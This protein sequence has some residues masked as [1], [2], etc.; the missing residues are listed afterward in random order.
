MN[1]DRMSSMPG[2]EFDARLARYLEWESR[3]LHPIP[4]REELA[5]GSTTIG[6]PARRASG[7]VIRSLVGALLVALAIIGLIVGIGALL[8]GPA[9]EPL[10]WTP[11]RYAQD[12]PAPVR[13]E[14]AGGAAVLQMGFG[15]D[16]RWDE[17][18]A[19][20]E[21][22]EYVDVVGDVGTDKPWLDIDTV[23]LGYGSFALGLSLAGEMPGSVPSPEETWVAYGV[24][25]DTNGDGLPDERFGIDNMPN[26][27]H[28]AWYTD[29]TSGDTAWSAGAPYGHVGQ[30][31]T[32][33]IVLD[34]WYPG[35]E[36]TGA[37]A[38]FRYWPARG[39]A[40]RFYMWA[41]VIEH[42][43][44][45]GTDYA[46]DVGWLVPGTQPELTLVGPT[47][48]TEA[49]LVGDGSLTMVQTLRFT[50]DGQ[51]K[52]DAGC[53]RGSANVTV[54]QGTLR[55]GD[56][57]LSDVPCRTGDAKRAS[58]ELIA[59]LSVDSIDFAIVGSTLELRLDSVVLRFTAT[60]S[61]PPPPS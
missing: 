41:S 13:D 3:Q 22:Y 51:I 18:E 15:E 12:W 11:D 1:Q 60:Y 19:A 24:V 16:T 58:A 21:P 53:T 40:A 52:I 6:T 35:E 39:E 29:L 38:A 33:R 54:E 8:R 59:R 4:R 10:T 32:A 49:N 37:D 9:P 31:G 27:E 42:G 5:M 48:Y 56:L 28:R 43:A 45:V 57:A 47:W 44:V 30:P 50:N 23:S 25:F 36:S 14:P 34:T 20:W 17:S 7:F 2:D 55:M 26:G 46:P 61:G